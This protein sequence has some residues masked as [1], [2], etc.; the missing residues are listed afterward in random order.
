M[1]FTSHPRQFWKGIFLSVFC[2]IILAKMLAAVFY[3]N[4]APFLPCDSQPKL[5]ENLINM[6]MDE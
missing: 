4:L 2:F 3:F 1:P 5:N 6:L